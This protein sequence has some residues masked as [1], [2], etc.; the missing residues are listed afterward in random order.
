MKNMKSLTALLLGATVLLSACSKPD[1]NERTLVEVV[2]PG[3]AANYGVFVWRQKRSANPTL[4][5]FGLAAFQNGSPDY[6]ALLGDVEPFGIA[7]FA[8]SQVQYGWSDLKDFSVCAAKFK[9]LKTR[10]S[11]VFSA[12][13]DSTNFSSNADCNGEVFSSFPPNVGAQ[14]KE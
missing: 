8:A 4:V 3:P 14:P 11:S 5:Y 6:D 2:Q 7:D 10:E 9:Q 13:M 1:P 12:V